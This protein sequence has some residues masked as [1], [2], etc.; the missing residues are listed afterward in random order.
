MTPKR[1]W[2]IPILFLIIWII[3]SSIHDYVRWYYHD[4]FWV[5]GLTMVIS[6]TLAITLSLINSIL[7]LK[8]MILKKIKYHWF[9][10]IMNLSP[11]ILILLAI[12]YEAIK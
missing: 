6:A 2:I 11:L 1:N 9:V 10:L 7:M 12:I 4:F 8:Q 5:V 3:T